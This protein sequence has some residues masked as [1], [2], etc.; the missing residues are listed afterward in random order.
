MSVKNWYGQF[1]VLNYWELIK[2]IFLRFA[3]LWF[4]GGRYNYDAVN[5]MNFENFFFFNFL[6]Y[7]LYLLFFLLYF[8]ILLHFFVF[9]VFLLLLLLFKTF[10]GIYSTIKLLFFYRYKNVIIYI[11]FTHTIS[12]HVNGS[13]NWLRRF[14]KFFPYLS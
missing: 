5:N 14:S 3:V 4:K 13:R 1:C 6:K 11:F 8:F 7:F 10:T 9:F 12:V 2:I